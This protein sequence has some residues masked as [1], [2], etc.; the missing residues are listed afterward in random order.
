MAEIPP[1]KFTSLGVDLAKIK[2]P[3]HPAVWLPTVSITEIQDNTAMSRLEDAQKHRHFA[4]NP[5][6]GYEGAVVNGRLDVF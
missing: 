2:P 5:D 1:G 4:S 3:A 6:A